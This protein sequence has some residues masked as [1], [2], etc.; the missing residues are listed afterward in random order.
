MIDPYILKAL[1]RKM[2]FKYFRLSP[3]QQILYPLSR[4]PQITGIEIPLPI[5]N[6][7]VAQLPP[8]PTPVP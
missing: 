1:P 2:R 8:V 6:L 4:F 7:A 3:V 5:Q